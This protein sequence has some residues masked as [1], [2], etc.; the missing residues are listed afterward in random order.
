MNLVTPK[1]GAK[2]K[3]LFNEL[4]SACANEKRTETQLERA[5]KYFISGSPTIFKDN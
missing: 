1:A 2:H 4:D 5:L 3:L